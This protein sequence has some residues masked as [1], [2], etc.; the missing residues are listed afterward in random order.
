[1]YQD[2]ICKMTGCGCVFTPTTG[3]QKYCLG[4][5]QKAKKER[6]REQWKERSR[7]RN[8]YKEYTRRCKICGKKFT[9]HYSKKLYCGSDECE[10]ERIRLK[11]KS[12]HSKRSKEELKLKG[13]KYYNNNR[14]KCLLSKANVYR[15]KNP[16]AKEYSPGK[17]VKLTFN[18]VKE[19]IE[20][21]NYKLLSVNYNNNKEL[22]KLQCPNSH[23]WY[24]TFHSFKSGSRCMTC[25]TNNNYVS[26]PEQDIRDYFENN[27][28]ELN[29]VYNDRSVISPKELDFYFP[30]SKVA[31]EVCGLYWHGEGTTNTP[32]SY[33]YDKMMI[34][35]ENRVRLI[36]IFE[37]EI[38]NNF[39]IV[40]SRILQAIGK[41]KEVIYA[42]KCSVECISTT[43]ANKFFVNNHLQGRSTA[44]KI[45]AL[46]HKGKIV[47]VCSIGKIIRKHTS[48]MDTVELKRLCNLSNTH[49]VGGAS[50]LFSRA[51]E[52]ALEEGYSKIKS[53]CDMRYANIFNPV[54]EKLGF[55]L[56]GFTKYTPHYFKSGVRYRNFS[57]RK[58]KE[59]RLTGKTEY[60]LRKEQGYDRIWDCGH[61][62][63]VYYLT[64]L[65]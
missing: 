14:D 4:C 56:D 42:R 37:D 17:T 40:I 20:S 7:K 19:Y 11:N 34:C 52:Y 12:Y 29:V 23:E 53:Y 62:T 26:K 24:T 25:Y 57:L 51:K 2:K 49:V 63:Y 55:V 9:T 59:E 48:T 46:V 30:D 13:R 64:N 45:W 16:E 32:K 54:Y 1:M 21:N 38:Y 43:E 31:V 50:K 65:Y 58:S 27:Y 33:H 15:E 60:E 18:E 22:L 41:T 28:P 35:F 47:S 6:E 61:R 3:N 44:E 10:E 8:G 36:T 39:D 5:R